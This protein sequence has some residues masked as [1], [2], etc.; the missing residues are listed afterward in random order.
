MTSAKRRLDD[1]RWLDADGY[2]GRTEPGAGPRRYAPD[3][4]TFGPAVGERLPDVVLV[5][6]AGGV[7]DVHADRAGR[8]AIVCFERSVVW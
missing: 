1:G 4:F 5:D 2:V 6:A 3:G 7:V 8:R